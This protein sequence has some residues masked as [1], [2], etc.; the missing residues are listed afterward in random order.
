MIFSESYIF[1]KFDAFCKQLDKIVDIIRTVEEYYGLEQLKMEGT[2]KICENFRA[3]V[4]NIRKKNADCLDF[5]KPD[6][7][8]C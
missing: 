2:E 7:G 8:L 4:E 5:R 3:L 6:V 1:G